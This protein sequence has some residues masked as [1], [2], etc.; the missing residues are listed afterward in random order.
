MKITQPNPKYARFKGN[1]G[2]SLE[3]DKVYNLRNYLYAEIPEGFVMIIRMYHSTITF[4]QHQEVSLE[5]MTIFG[6]PEVDIY[7]VKIDE[8]QDSVIIEEEPKPVLEAE[9]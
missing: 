3:P 7:F 2:N 6:I 8:T 5:F 1:F 4:H 9:Q